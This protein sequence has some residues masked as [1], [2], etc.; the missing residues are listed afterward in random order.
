VARRRSPCGDR[1]PCDDHAFAARSR[2]R[3]LHLQ[4]H[5][6]ARARPRRLGRLLPRRAGH[7]PA[8]QV[9]FPR[10]EVLAVLSGL[11][12]R[13]RD[14]PRRCARARQ[15]HLRARDDAGAYSQLGNGERSELPRLSQR[16]RRAA[17]LRSSRHQRA[18]CRCCLRTFR[19]ARRAV[20]ET[21]AGRQ[22]EGDRLHHRPR[23]LLDRDP[24]AGEHDSRRRRVDVRCR[25]GDDVSSSSCVSATA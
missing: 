10:D 4:P 6:A 17:R 7:D 21:S 14:H 20:Q 24:G 25:R 3:G 22:D 16:Q 8:A 2:N 9:R 1:G 5:H 19:G 11:S 12:A 15:L 13:G 18:G 23:R